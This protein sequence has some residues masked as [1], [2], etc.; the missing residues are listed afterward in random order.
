MQLPFLWE[1]FANTVMNPR[2]RLM[3]EKAFMATTFTRKVPR[4][5][6][7]SVKSSSGTSPTGLRYNI[8][9]VKKIPFFS[10]K[11]FQGGF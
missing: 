5:G 1:L 4:E 7:G 10:V 8:Q 6:K 3:F 2:S 9:F 11:S